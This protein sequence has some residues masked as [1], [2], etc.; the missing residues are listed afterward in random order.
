MDLTSAVINEQRANNWKEID[1]YHART[2]FTEKGFRLAN[3][4]ILLPLLPRKIAAIAI[5]YLAYP[6]ALGSF[7]TGKENV[8]QNLEA[9]NQ[10]EREGYFIKKITIC[11]SGVQ[12]DAAIIGN[13]KTI[14]NGKWTLHALGN[15][16]SMEMV[17]DDLPRANYKKG[18]N[19]LL[20]NGPSVGQSNGWPTRYQL[21]AGFEAG[22]QFLEEKVQ[23]KHIALHGLSLGGGMMSE[24]ILNHDFS[25][26]LSRGIKYLVISDRTFCKL[27]DI[28]SNLIGVVVKPIFYLMGMELDV[29][30][31]AKKLSQLGIEQIIIQ[32]DPFDM[33]YSLP[34]GDDGVIP[35]EVS[36][37]SRLHRE[38]D[39]KNKVFLESGMITHNGPLPRDI[40]RELNSKT[41]QFFENRRF[42]GFF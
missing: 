4:S 6:A 7:L 27:S 36:L 35:S 34:R 20:I 21:G 13:K 2:S 18:S 25:S 28:A 16:M 31:A 37:A 33:R 26:G 3:A 29:V 12:Y 22:I 23:A 38:K 1:T 30:K 10:L 39:L 41:N 42:F 14:G 5:G 15:G 24:A 40:E 32:H 17:Y 19:T 8:S 11:K 9:L